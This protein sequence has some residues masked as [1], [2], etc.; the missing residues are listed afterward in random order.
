MALVLM[1]LLSSGKPLLRFIF[2]LQK[3]LTVIFRAF[4]LNSREQLKQ[5]EAAYLARNSKQKGDKPPKKEK[6]EKKEKKK[7]SGSLQN[8]IKGDTSG[9]Y[10]CYLCIT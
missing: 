1:M 9:Y 5:V 6:K 4:V 10:H 8:D 3:K 7:S 2:K